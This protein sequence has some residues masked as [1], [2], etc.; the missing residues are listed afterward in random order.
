[1]DDK[2]KNYNNL[3]YRIGVGMVIINHKKEI[4]TG[5]R[6]DSARQYWQM[7]QGGIILGETYSKAVLREMK[8]EIGCNKAIIMAESRNWYSYHIPKFLVHKLWNSNFKGQKQKWFLIKFLGKD[9]DININT[10]YPEFSQWKWMNSSQLIN[11]ALPFKRKLYKAVI[12]EFH[13]FLL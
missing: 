12:N 7:P 13:I 10:I 5:Q 2:I 1:M 11:N 4:F 6:I 3:P 8:E 9:E